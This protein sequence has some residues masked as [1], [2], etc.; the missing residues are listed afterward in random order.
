MRLRH[1]RG[2]R[3][4]RSISE[5]PVGE[6]ARQVILILSFTVCITLLLT[7]ARVTV[8][9]LLKRDHC[10]GSHSLVAARKLA[11]AA[12]LLHHLYP[13]PLY[14]STLPSS[15]SMT[16]PFEKTENWIERGPDGHNFYVRKKQ[17][18]GLPS[19][20]AIFREAIHDLIHGPSPFWKDFKRANRERSKS[21]PATA[22]F[23]PYVFPQLVNNPLPPNISRVSLASSIRRN[24]PPP[25]MQPPQDDQ[26][27]NNT[28]QPRGILKPE[29]QRFSAGPNGGPPMS[30]WTPTAM[31]LFPPQPYPGMHPGAIQ[32]YGG[33][34]PQTGY[35]GH[36]QV[37]HPMQNHMPNTNIPRGPTQ[38]P[39]GFQGLALPPDARAI[40]PPRY[41]TQDDLKYKCAICGRFR[42]TR[43]HY[44]HPLAP[45]Q[46]PGT[47][48]CRRCRNTETD[49]E[50]EATESDDS[51]GS[52]RRHRRESRHA[53]RSS[54]GRSRSRR[55][56]RRRSPGPTQG[57]I[58]W[59]DDDEY[60]DY[61]PRSR[62]RTLSR[63][64]SQDGLR[65]ARSRSIL[66]R[67]RSPSVEE[68][69]Y[70]RQ[71]RTRPTRRIVYVED[72]PA[73]F[74]GPEEEEVEVRT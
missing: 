6:A 33:Y 27:N 36:P 3:D 17:Q 50:D 7:P 69:E 1:V 71:P 42:S 24:L 46:L 2:R 66:R 44:E 25:V 35:N 53:H 62:V 41:P 65:R 60:D 11:F 29:Q 13:L 28:N 47:T 18:S 5:Q 57:R 64:G 23:P 67:R 48:I 74:S 22:P 31:P 10:S 32:G 61:E 52:T 39:G 59:T 19:F 21:N 8:I 14:L 70:V 26:N 38:S 45:G 34:P 30:G 58:V 73:Y 20:K 12:R 40:S 37:F 16:S 49:S 54:F 72:D 55:S 63:S 9:L 68:V 4:A 43:Y 56:R 15:S 51:H